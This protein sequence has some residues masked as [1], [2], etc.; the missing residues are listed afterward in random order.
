MSAEKRDV[1]VCYGI[2]GTAGLIIVG[3]LVPRTYFMFERFAREKELVGRF[4]PTDLG[5]DP[6]MNNVA[7]QVS[8]ESFSS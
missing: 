2:L 8:V 4:E 1:I 3:I 5:P 6:R 7:R